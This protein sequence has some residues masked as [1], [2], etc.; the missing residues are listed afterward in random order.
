MKGFCSKVIWAVGLLAVGVVLFCGGWVGLQSLAPGKDAL[1]EIKAIP[2]PA[3][4]RSIEYT[5]Q[6]DEG[7]L[8]LT[9][10]PTRGR[11]VGVVTYLTADNPGLVFSHYRGVLGGGWSEN[12][13][14]TA[15]YIGFTRRQER[16]NGMRVSF[17]TPA[18]AP[19]IKIDVDQVIVRSQLM[20]RAY[21]VY[22]EDEDAEMTSVRVSLQTWQ[23]R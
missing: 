14:T 4:V 2:L 3:G 5:T 15:K 8:G 12:W 18:S 20:V 9:A 19:W 13:D 11:G 23:G 6:R 21:R 7:L 10:S 1:A 16:F 17:P 22:L